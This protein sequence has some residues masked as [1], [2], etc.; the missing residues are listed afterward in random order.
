M[1]PFQIVDHGGFSHRDKGS[2]GLAGPTGCQDLLGI[3]FV[4]SALGASSERPQ[5]PLQGGL[6]LV[7]PVTVH[8]SVW[9]QPQCTMMSGILQVPETESEQQHV[10]PD[11]ARVYFCS[12]C[13]GHR[14][15]SFLNLLFFHNC[16]YAFSIT[17]VK[18]CDKVM[19]KAWFEKHGA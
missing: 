1:L 16:S 7:H 8:K 6:Y 11:D 18:S 5:R 17:C 2:R 19:E 4:L 14:F 3:D 15:F 9:Q 10:Q 12:C 13:C